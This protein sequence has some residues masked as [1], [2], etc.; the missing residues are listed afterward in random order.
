MYISRFATV[1]S[2]P[3]I[4]IID[5]MQY[6]FDNHLRIPLFRRSIRYDHSYSNCVSNRYDRLS[7]GVCEPKDNCNCIQTASVLW[8]VFP[9]ATRGITGWTGSDCSIPMCSQVSGMRGRGECG[10]MRDV[11]CVDHS[12]H[13]AID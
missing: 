11:D 4:I 5:I 8:E 12:R 2:V 7:Q 1:R 6:L 10:W 3:L 9:G 13:G